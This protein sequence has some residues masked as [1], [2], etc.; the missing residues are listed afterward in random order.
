MVSSTQRDRELIANL[1]PKCAALR[2]SGVVRVRGLS[3]AD[4]VRVLGDR[5]N[6][7]SVTNP[8]RL[9]QSQ[10][11][12]IDPLGPR[13]VLWLSCMLAIMTMRCSGSR[14]PRPRHLRRIGC[15]GR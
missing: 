7:I 4:Q 8:A 1:A 15:Q 11:A 10:Y 6:V 9:R 3:T 12:L 2:E 14:F 5:S 13:P